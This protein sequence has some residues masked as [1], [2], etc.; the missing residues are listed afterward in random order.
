MMKMMA[1]LTWMGWTWI[2]GCDGDGD[3]DSP[4]IKSNIYVLCWWVMLRLGAV[5]DDTSS[6]KAKEM[7]IDNNSALE[8]L[9]SI[10]WMSQ[11]LSP[12]ICAQ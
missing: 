5:E 4:V 2:G 8:L 7:L 11:M 1:V 3:E 10:A 12:M 9:D 6:T